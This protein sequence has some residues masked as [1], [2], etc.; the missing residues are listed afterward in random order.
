MKIM[1]ICWQVNKFVHFPSCEQM[2]CPLAEPAFGSILSSFENRSVKKG[3][4]PIATPLP[5]G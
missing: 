4:Q 3:L 1:K 2:G 5:T